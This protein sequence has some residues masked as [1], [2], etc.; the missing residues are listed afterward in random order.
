[1]YRRRVPFRP[2]QLRNSA[3]NGYQNCKQPTGGKSADCIEDE[4]VAEPVTSKDSSSG[5]SVDVS[6]MDGAQ[7]RK[8]KPLVD[9]TLGTKVPKMNQESCKKTAGDFIVHLT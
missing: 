6:P 7:K 9:S 4:T 5:T 3:Q 2:I 1:M 8:L